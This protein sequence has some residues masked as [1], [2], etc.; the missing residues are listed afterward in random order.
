M[1]VVCSTYGNR[2]LIGSDRLY[3][4]GAD[5]EVEKDGSPTD[6]AVSLLILG[7]NKFNNLELLFRQTLLLNITK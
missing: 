5:Q 6:F 1:Y 3:S 2:M 4:Q 7:D